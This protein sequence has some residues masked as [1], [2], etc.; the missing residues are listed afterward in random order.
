MQDHAEKP[1]L[2]F[3]SSA[4]EMQEPQS[5]RG[6]TVVKPAAKIGRDCHSIPSLSLIGQLDEYRFECDL[7]AIASYVEV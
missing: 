1:D 2:A 4:D 3:L 6:F 7:S 5:L